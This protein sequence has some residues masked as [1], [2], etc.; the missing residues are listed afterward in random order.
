MQFLTIFTKF[1]TY[2]KFQNQKIA[3]PNTHK[4]KYLLSLR[5]S[6]P[7]IW[8]K[9]DTDT[10]ISHISTY[11][12]KIRV[13][14]TYLITITLTIE[15]LIFNG[16]FVSYFYWN[17]KIKYL[18]N[19]LQSP[20]H[21]IKYPQNVIFFQS[22]NLIPLRWSIF[23]IIQLLNYWNWQATTE[24]TTKTWFRLYPSKHSPWLLTSTLN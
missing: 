20:N 22:Q 9:C 5:F 23:F 14:V 21:E 13:S 15:K 8:L 18:S 4:I 11:S 2:I 6:F 1:C 3:K 16:N 19:V 12:T 7:N 10:H 17:R 24:T